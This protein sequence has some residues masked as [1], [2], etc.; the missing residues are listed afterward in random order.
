ML[1]FRVKNWF[2]SYGNKP[3]SNLSQNFECYISFITFDKVY[4]FHTFYTIFTFV[5]HWLLLVAIIQKLSNLY[6][7]NFLNLET[8]LRLKR[9]MTGNFF[10]ICFQIFE[11]SPETMQPKCHSRKEKK[12][13]SLKK[14][15]VVF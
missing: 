6:T 11:I 1:C 8:S 9:P 10:L 4:T 13:H 5:W 12:M 7:I 15:C 14:F 2:N 3:K